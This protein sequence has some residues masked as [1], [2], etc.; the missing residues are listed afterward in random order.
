MAR[1][2]DFFKTQLGDQAAV[3]NAWMLWRRDRDFTAKDMAAE[4]PTIPLSAIQGHL[5]RLVG[6]HP[7]RGGFLIRVAPGTFCVNPAKSP[8]G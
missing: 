7:E 1:Q 6:E 3:M 8:L 2:E 5:Q 4:L